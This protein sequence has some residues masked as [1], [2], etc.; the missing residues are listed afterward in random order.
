LEKSRADTASENA[1]LKTEVTKLRRDFEEIK[2]KGITTSPAKND[3]VNAFTKIENS[4]DNPPEQI[5]L[6]CND[7]PASK[8]DDDAKGIDQ[9][10][11]NS[12]SSKMKNSNDTLA[13]NISDN[14]SNSDDADMRC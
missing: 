5:D 6:R 12:I 9:F 7:T 2:S 1:E 4:N 11:V 3:T 13:S 10:S 14:T 8:S